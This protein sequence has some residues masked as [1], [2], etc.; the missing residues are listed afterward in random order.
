M[1]I[2]IQVDEDIAEML[3]SLGKGWSGDKWV[4]RDLNEVVEAILHQT[5]YIWREG[6][7]PA[8]KKVKKKQPRAPEILDGD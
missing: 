5:F 4:F 1:K 8:Q 3:K 2:Q 7:S 6:N